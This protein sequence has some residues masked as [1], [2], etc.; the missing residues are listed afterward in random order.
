MRK[1]AFVRLTPEQRT[2]LSDRLE[3]EALN[4]RRRRHFQI[5]LL[6]DEGRTDE[7]IAAATG[8]SRS[9]VERHR[10]RFAREGL[11]AALADK[12]RSGAPAKLDGKQEAMIVALACSDAPEGQAR[13]TAKRLADRAVELEVVE[14]VSESTV[15]RVLKETRRSPGRSGRGASRRSAASSWPGWRTSWSCT[16]SRWTKRG[17]WSAWTS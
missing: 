10:T 15:R 1:A 2:E 8:A 9:T 16:P 5:L 14:S 12:P 6:A 11:E 3:R 7:Q 17:R 13:W 4:G